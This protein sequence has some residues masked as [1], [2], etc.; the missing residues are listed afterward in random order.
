MSH[1]SVTRF[2][3]FMATLLAVLLMT[4][5]ANAQNPPAFPRRAVIKRGG[6]E[7]F[8]EHKVRYDERAKPSS[9]RLRSAGKGSVGQHIGTSHATDVTVTDMGPEQGVSFSGAGFVI[10]IKANRVIYFLGRV[11]FSKDK[12]VYKC[13]EIGSVMIRCIG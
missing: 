1:H 7:R 6:P 5:V 3:A 9:M 11:L 8:D 13:I 10:Q 2:N 12:A 4:I